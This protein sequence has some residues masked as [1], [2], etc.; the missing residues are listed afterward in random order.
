[1]L[2]DGIGD[3]GPKHVDGAMGKIE[4]PQDAKGEGKTRGDEKEQSAPGN[5]THELIKKDV[6]G[7][8][9]RYLK[10]EIQISKLETNPKFQ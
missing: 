3:K 1:L 7:H 2:P 10:S 5:S 6:K 8:I 9:W 4:N